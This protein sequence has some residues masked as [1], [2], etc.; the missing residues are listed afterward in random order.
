MFHFHIDSC[1]F[2]QWNCLM[3]WHNAS[4]DSPKATL[5]SGSLRLPGGV[6]GHHQG[7]KFVERLLFLEDM[8]WS[9]Y[10]G[11]FLIRS[12]IGIDGFFFVVVSLFLSC[13]TQRQLSVRNW[14]N[15]IKC[16]TRPIL[17]S[18]TIVSLWWNH[19]SQTVGFS[20]VRKA[21]KK[22]EV[23]GK[24]GHGDAKGGW[25]WTVEECGWC[26]RGGK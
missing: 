21:W 7:P 3:C 8:E 16:W 22:E 15:D 25:Q 13:V 17:K 9:S 23:G 12:R 20:A 2:G 19:P 1:L 26:R 10:V 6:C 4:R 5:C 24:G 18:R 14:R 11:W